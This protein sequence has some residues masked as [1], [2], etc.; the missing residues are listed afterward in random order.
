[1]TKKSSDGPKLEKPMVFTLKTIQGPLKKELFCGFPRCQRIVL[2]LSTTNIADFRKSTPKPL[3]FKEEDI[4]IMEISLQGGNMSSA[5]RDK[6]INLI[7]LCLLIMRVHL[8][9]VIK[10]STI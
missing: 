9:N 7:Y 6:L 4:Q 1:M 8:F 2:N 10:S 3:F 5:L